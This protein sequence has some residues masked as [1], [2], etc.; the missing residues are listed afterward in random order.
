MSGN[1]HSRAVHALF[2]RAREHDKNSPMTAKKPPTYRAYCSLR[3]GR[4]AAGRWIET[5]FATVADDGI[6]LKIYLET[7]PVSGFDGHILLRP[8][9]AKP[10]MPFPPDPE[11]EDEDEEMQH[12]VADPSAR[13]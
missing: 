6:G 12:T 3:A 5:G 2:S 4:R 13:H 1:A 10:E 8:V 9:D 11:D 7:L